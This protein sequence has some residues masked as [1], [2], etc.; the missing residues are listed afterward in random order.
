MF[1]LFKKNKSSNL[2]K[3][4]EELMKKAI[5]AQRKGDIALFS[6]LSAQAEEVGKKIDELNTSNI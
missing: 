4:Y 5:E 6:E 3:K 2:Q 1:G